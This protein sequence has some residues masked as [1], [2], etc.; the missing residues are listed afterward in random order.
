[1]MVDTIQIE[2]LASR[3]STSLNQK[4]INLCTKKL[5]EFASYQFFQ[6]VL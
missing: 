2:V 3:Y 4:K 1:M 6:T 5:C